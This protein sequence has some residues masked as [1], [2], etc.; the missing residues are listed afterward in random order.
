MK[1]LIEKLMQMKQARDTRNEL[2]KMTDRE[3]ADIGIRRGDI[4][5]LV[6]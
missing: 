2:D 6:R 5:Y 4:P 1:K 3:L